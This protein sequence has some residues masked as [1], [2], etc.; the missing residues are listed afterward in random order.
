MIHI[1]TMSPPQ[2]CRSLPRNPTTMQTR[3]PERRPLC[4]STPVV[5]MVA[6]ALCAGGVVVAA[7][8]ANATGT[9]L[10][11]DGNKAVRFNLASHQMS[12]MRLS[13]GTTEMLGFGGGVATD[14][15]VVKRIS[16]AADRYSLR[17]LPAGASAGATL[18]PFAVSRGHVSGPVQ[19]SPSAMLFAMHSLESAGLS[20]PIVDHIYVFDRSSHVR[21]RVA[22][23]RDPAW[24]SEDRLVVAGDDGLFTLSVGAAPSAQRIGQ[25]GLGR[26]GQVPSRP[27]VSPDAH[28]IVFVQGDAVWRMGI[29]GQGLRRLTLARPGQT[30]PAW[31]PDGAHVAVVRRAC[32]PVGGASPNPELV[33]VSSSEADQD[34]ERLPLVKRADGLPVRSCGPLYW[35]P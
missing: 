25:R 21:M 2:C 23:Y 13:E 29:D 16:A 12:S 26:P 7:G 4:T 20:E 8:A 27:A 32:P 28:T 15:G 33:I 19:P 24:I 9:L 31:S 5:A 3:L 18:P 14:V 30:W 10:F 22:G 34:I 6:L 11:G 35:L 17:L 1:D